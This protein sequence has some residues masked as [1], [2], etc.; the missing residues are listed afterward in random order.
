MIKKILY[1]I[2]PTVKLEEYGDSIGS[3]RSALQL[4]KTLNDKQAETA[5]TKALED[6]NIKLDLFYFLLL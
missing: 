5:I 6:V 2:N 4:A 1:F 3:F